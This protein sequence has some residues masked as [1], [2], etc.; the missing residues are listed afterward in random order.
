MSVVPTCSEIDGFH[1]G[2]TIVSGP[3]KYLAELNKAGGSE[4]SSVYAI[5]SKYDEVV[6]YECIVWGKITCRIPG[7]QGEIVK[8]S[9]EWTHMN[10]RDKTGPDMITWL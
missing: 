9:L 6:M 10:L 1:P 4:G 2:L 5:W 7:Q 8:N 3:S